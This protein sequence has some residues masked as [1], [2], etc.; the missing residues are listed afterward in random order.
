MGGGQSGL[1][2]LDTS[3]MF[4]RQL[5]FK[6]SQRAFTLIELLITVTVLGVLTAIALPNLRDFIVSNRLSS[7]VNGFIGL[8]NY[9][10]SE[11]IVRN[12]SVLVC[13]KQAAN[14]E[15][16]TAEIWSEL[17]I[18]AF[19]DVNGNNSWDA[20]DVLL[21][22]IPA[23]DTTGNQTRFKKRTSA[24]PSFIDFGASGTATTTYQF[25]I[26]AISAA[27]TAYEI[28]YGRT[29]CISRPGRARVTPFTNGTCDTF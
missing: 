12:Q 9:A 3:R 1:P 16:S 8:L 23:M 7:Q 2:L 4:N 19:V 25:S 27:D 10:R 13:A 22:R 17:E 18:Q 15:C 29:I 14:N 20:G 5:R 26:N 28:R 21:K 6:H 24:A 11:A